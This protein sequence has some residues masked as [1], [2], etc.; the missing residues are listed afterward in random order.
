LI[1]LVA[2]IG[3]AAIGWLMWRASNRGDAA[4]GTLVDATTA[5]APITTETTLPATTAPEPSA[6]GLTVAP[7]SQD[8]GVMRKG[9]RAVRT[10]TLRNETDAPLSIKVSRS[11]CRC[12][13]Y[14]HPPVI[15]PKSDK[16]LSVTIDGA[17]AKAGDLRE[18]V[19]VTT[20]DPSVKTSV[21][22]I[23]TIR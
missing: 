2:M 4:T 9:T 3:L 15:P 5:T 14:Q 22:V 20:S 12:L 10:F 1:V 6:G 21:D 23:A 7:A 8:Y 13:Y 16:T 11:V 19:Q 18:T 17:K